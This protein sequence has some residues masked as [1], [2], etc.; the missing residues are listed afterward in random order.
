MACPMLQSPTPEVSVGSFYREHLTE[1]LRRVGS[2]FCLMVFDSAGMAVAVFAAAALLDNLQIWSELL[3]SLLP[4][5]IVFLLLVMNGLHLYEQLPYRR[6][7]D[8]VFLGFSIPWVASLLASY[9]YKHL[10]G[11]DSILLLGWSIGL[12]LV[13]VGRR[14]YDAFTYNWRRCRWAGAATLF[15]GDA[16]AEAQLRTAFPGLL[17]EWQIVGRIA[18]AASL[19]DSGAIGT[20][21]DLPQLLERYSVRCIILAASALASQLF[22]TVVQYCDYADVKLLV[23]Q[24]PL[25]THKRLG[26]FSSAVWD[27]APVLEVRESWSYTAQLIGKRVIDFVGAGLGILFLSPLMLGIALLIRLDSEGPIFFRQP[28]LGRGGKPFIVWKFRTMEVNAEKRLKELEQLN[29]SKGGVLFKMKEDPRVTRT[30]KFLRRTSLDELPQLFNVLQGQMSLVGPRPLQLRDSALASKVN[31]DVFAKRLTVMP[32]VT[33]L[34]QV[35]GRSEVSFDEMLHLDIHYIEHW[36]LLLDL[37][38]IWRTI[39]VVLTRK[40]AY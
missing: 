5:A 11:I 26:I 4:V 36:S 25:S 23:L 34:W 39:Q 18:P 24:P 21:E 38:I 3:V 19:R 12:P 32:G 20:I 2:V 30:G 9:Y 35:S 22:Q 31:P 40:G 7:Y 6:R 33:G 8:L 13:L 29:E 10:T 27:K 28:R 14:I 1:L 15:V 16:E 17:P 37:R